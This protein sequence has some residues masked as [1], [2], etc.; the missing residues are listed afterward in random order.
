MRGRSPRTG[1]PVDE[2]VRIAREVAGA[3]DYAHRHGIV[4][5]DIKPENILLQDGHVLVADFGIGKATARW[6]PRRC[7]RRISATGWHAGLHEPGTGVGR[8]G[9]R[10]QRIY[11]L[12]CVLYEMLV[13]EPPFTGPTV[14]AVIAKRFSQTPADV[15][16]VREGVPHRGPGRARALSR[17]R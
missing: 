10:A 15:V 6:T 12:G 3:L 16:G 11:S 1:L 5:R 7:R 2:A 13:G 9:R 17:A 4:H 14:Q 8:A